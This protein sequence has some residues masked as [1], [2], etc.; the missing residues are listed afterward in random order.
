MFL[1]SLQLYNRACTVARYSY[2]QYSCTLEVQTRLVSS[3]HS[4][5]SSYTVGHCCCRS[6]R[7]ICR[8]SVWEVH[9]HHVISGLVTTPLVSLNGVMLC[10]FIALYSSP[11][12]A[13]RHFSCLL[14]APLSGISCRIGMLAQFIIR[15]ASFPP[16]NAATSASQPR[17]SPLSRRHNLPHV[18]PPSVPGS[19]P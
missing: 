7:S 11:R 6:A 9:H 19:S 14:P 15:L 5:F 16:C 17:S 18:S 8:G 13:I 10:H 2:M 12:S 1:V 4:G 3:T